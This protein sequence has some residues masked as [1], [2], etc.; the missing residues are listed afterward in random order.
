METILICICV[1]LFLL[2]VF[3]L[4]FNSLRIRNL[5]EELS[6]IGMEQSKLNFR[7]FIIEKKQTVHSENKLM[8]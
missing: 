2:V 4:I 8:E 6:S 7:L 1:L 3:L 5:Q